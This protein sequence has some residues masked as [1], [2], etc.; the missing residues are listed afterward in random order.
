M[1][2][3]DRVVVIEELRDKP[4]M[5][6]KIGTVLD[7]RETSKRVCVEFDEPMGGHFNKDGIK[8]KKGHCWWVWEKELELEYDSSKVRWYYKGKLEKNILNYNNFINESMIDGLEFKTLDK[9][10]MEALIDQIY[11]ISSRESDNNKHWKRWTKEDFL[12]D[13]PGK[14]KYSIVAMLGDNVVAF[15]INSLKTKGDFSFVHTNRLLKDKR[16]KEFHIFKDIY[17]KLFLTIKENG[18][19]YW[20]CFTPFEKVK[21]EEKKKRKVFYLT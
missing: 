4:G 19:T 3:G 9:E 15:Q 11:E 7:T 2:K 18:L 21:E 13:L 1:E 12:C 17:E 8:G 16:Y 14:W 20:T 5:V 10:N 6:G